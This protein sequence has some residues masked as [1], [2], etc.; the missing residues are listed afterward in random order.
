MCHAEFFLW[1]THEKK[2][3]WRVVF[4]ESLNRKYDSFSWWEKINRLKEENELK[5]CISWECD[6]KNQAARKLTRFSSRLKWGG[7]LAK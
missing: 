7:R 3:D 1:A 4:N 5:N 2:K 6:E